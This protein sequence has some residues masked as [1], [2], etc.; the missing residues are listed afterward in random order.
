MSD[1]S[2]SSETLIISCNFI[3]FRKLMHI[4]VFQITLMTV[5]K[6]FLL[7]DLSLTNFSSLTRND[8]ESLVFGTW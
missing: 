2:S 1:S 6:L 3:G 5:S 8:S 4:I 7:N